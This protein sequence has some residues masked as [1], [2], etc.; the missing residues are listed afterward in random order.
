MRGTGL[1]LSH[2]ATPFINRREAG[3]LLGMQL[4]RYRD[5]NPI[6][7]GIPPGGMTIAAEIARI[8]AAD[9]DFLIV[10]RLA[11]P[12]NHEVSLGAVTEGGTT[13]ITELA[14]H[15]NRIDIERLEAERRQ[16][17]K[18][19][20]EATEQYRRRWPKIPLRH[21]MVVVADEGATSGA[22]MRAALRAIRKERPRKVVAT[23]PICGRGVVELIARDADELVC[24]RSPPFFGA[25]RD[26]YVEYPHLSDGDAMRPLGR[27]AVESA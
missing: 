26:S 7:L 16:Q 6:V 18:E 11:A 9:L 21:R 27:R 24:L 12:G 3:M 22:T 23:L 17:V 20:A 25:I 13:F 15:Q 10:R 4:M 1:I 8:L 19:V 5:L 2:S 14:V